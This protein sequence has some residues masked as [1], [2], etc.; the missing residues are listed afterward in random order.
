MCH[1]YERKEEERRG[2]KAD[3]NVKPVQIIRDFTQLLALKFFTKLLSKL[4]YIKRGEP[5]FK[6]LF[7]ENILESNLS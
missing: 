4:A 5:I 3:V 1:L 6:T 2:R 7:I